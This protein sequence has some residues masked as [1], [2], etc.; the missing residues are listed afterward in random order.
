MLNIENLRVV[1][2]DGDAPT[3]AVDGVS[4]S[5]A[6]GEILGVV[7]ESG[8]GKSMSAYAIMGLLRGRNATIEGKI[9]FE[10]TNLLALDGKRLR[11][12]QGAEIGIVFQEPMTS[13]N[14]TMRIGAQVEEALRVHTRMKKD[15]RRARALEAMRL[16]GLDAPET[17][18]RRYPHALSGGQRQRVMI[19]AALVL[20]PKLLIADE[21][22]TAL[23]VTLQAQL[24]DTLREINRA[25][26]TAI[27]FI[28]H[29]LGVIRS[30]CSRVIVMRGG[31]IVEQGG[32]EQVFSSPQADYTRTLI[33]AKPKLEF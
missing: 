30:L 16:A 14:P 10:G 22:T 3:V 24:L 27:L 7:G 19:A 33:A 5:M 26:G 6:R 12:I 9:E 2:H 29:D 13:L 15:E 23:D 28:S 11:G 8:S 21:P 1:F 32:A 18:Y 25:Q 4:F 31:H 17:L 20:K